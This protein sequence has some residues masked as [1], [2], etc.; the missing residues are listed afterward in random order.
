MKAIAAEALGGPEVLQLTEVETPQPAP[1]MVLIKV[2]AAALNYADV[3]MRAGVYPGG[4]QPPFVPG[5]EVAGTVAEGP[6]QGERVMALTW[7]GGYAEYALAN[8]NAVWP[9]PEGMSSA[10]AAGFL[11][12]NLTAYFALWMADLKPDERVLIHAAAGGVGTAAVQLAHE[13]GAEIFATS[14][15]EEKLKRIKALGAEHGI[16]YAQSDFAAEVRRLTHDEGVDIVLEMIGGEVFERSL[17]L[18]RNLGRMVLY[19]RVSGEGRMIDPAVL[20]TNSLGLHGLYL[21]GL[22]ADADLMKM[23]MDDLRE[24]VRRKK[25]RVMVGKHFTLAEAAEAHRFL[26]SRQSFGKI[27]LT[28]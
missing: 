18:L 16:N 6:R 14:S 17:E 13:M 24:Y 9:I 23:A 20:L 1:G 12:A 2:E 25:L 5:L 19:G 8:E 4:P 11:V 22:V 21:G 26:E 15:S 28:L 7:A 10:E 27:V 3:M